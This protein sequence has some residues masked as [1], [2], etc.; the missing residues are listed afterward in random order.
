[1]ARNWPHLASR[2]WKL[3]PLAWNEVIWLPLPFAVAS[4]ALVVQQDRAAGL[5]AIAFVVAER[6]LQ[7]RV[8]RQALVETLLEDLR[9]SSVKELAR[10][11]RTLS[12]TTDAPL[13]L[14]SPLP[15]ILPR[16]YRVTQHAEQYLSLQNPYRRRQAM[17]GPR[18][19][20]R[21]CSA[22]C[23]VSRERLRAADS[24][25]SAIPGNRSWTPPRHPWPAHRRV[26]SP[27]RSCSAIR[28]PAAIPTSLPVGEMWLAGS[29]TASW[30]ASKPHAVAARSAADGQDEHLEPAAAGCW[31]PTSPPP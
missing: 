25:K 3:H 20:C 31:V 27:T 12:W 30:A 5:R 19:K 17:S 13:D 10:V 29:K 7:R 28:C 2:M 1:M 15:E 16:V 22:A 26:R 4:L 24:A 11:S 14:P 23:P 8:A 6:R 18:R 21:R 9:A